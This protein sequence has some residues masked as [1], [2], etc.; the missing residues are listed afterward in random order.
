MAFFAKAENV[1]VIVVRGSAATSCLL[2][3]PIII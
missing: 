3:S 2:F 1:M